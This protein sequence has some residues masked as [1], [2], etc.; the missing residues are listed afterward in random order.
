MNSRWKCDRMCCAADTG[1]SVKGMS[2]NYKLHPFN[3]YPSTAAQRGKTLRKHSVYRT[4][5]TNF[6]ASISIWLVLHGLLA[7][8]WL[9]INFGI[10]FYT[11]AG[12]GF[13]PSIHHAGS[14]LEEILQ[15]RVITASKT[16]LS[17]QKVTRRNRFSKI[18]KQARLIVKQECSKCF[19]TYKKDKATFLFP[20]TNPAFVNKLIY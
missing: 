1:W 4:K 20:K 5:T 7:P 2:F 19:I 8:Q 9:Q 17:V 12:P 18:T 16:C 11:G 14:I 15:W 3:C 13:V 6:G 10:H